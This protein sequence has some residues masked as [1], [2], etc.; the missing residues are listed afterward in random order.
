MALCFVCI[1]LLE[2]GMDDVHI[3]WTEGAAEAV[4]SECPGIMFVT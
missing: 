3:L 2:G 1:P 4:I